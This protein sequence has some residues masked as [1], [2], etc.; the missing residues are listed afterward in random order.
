[1]SAA[2][3]T[4]ERL[5]DDETVRRYLREH[6]DFFARHPRLLA[7]LSLP[8]DAGRAVSLVER[9]VTLLRER[10]I[11]TRKRLTQLVAA[12]HDNESLFDKTRTLTLALLDARTPADVDDALGASLIANLR[13]D[14]VACHYCAPG[15]DA[16]RATAVC[17]GH[18]APE[19]FPLPNLLRAAD[20]TA[21][22]ILRAEEYEAMFGE[23]QLHGS[24]AIAAFS[25]RGI[26]GL[27]GIGS[28][29][30]K[31]FSADMGPLFVRYVCDV[32]ASVLCRMLEQARTR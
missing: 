3:G 12:A 23:R 4:V 24:A 5:L 7:E 15:P 27:F 11:D 25:H 6:P 22:G 10:N 26:V 1:M 8:H 14:H 30:P 32:L 28:R 9:Q 20:G 29:D 16:L 17:I 19:E 18:A 2:Q 21:C 13:A 31:R